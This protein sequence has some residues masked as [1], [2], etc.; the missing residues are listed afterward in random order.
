MLR[1]GV[2]S[3]S[4][5]AFPSRGGL[6][7][8]AV[9]ILDQA[10]AAAAAGDS[11]GVIRL[12]ESAA[13]STPG[14]AEIL[15]L[16]APALFQCGRF[17]DSCRR[18]RE[19][20]EL[21]PTDVKAYTQLGLAS[22][23][24]G[25]VN[26]FEAAMGLALAR[27]PQNEAALG[28][29]ARISFE[30]GRYAEA[31][32]FYGRLLNRGTRDADTFLGLGVCLAKGGEWEIAAETFARVILISPTHAVALENLAMAC[33]KMSWKRSPEP[34]VED[35]LGEAD[36]HRQGDRPA[37]QC[38]CLQAAIAL[39][40]GS[41]GPRMQLVCTLIDQGWTERLLQPLEELARVVP[42]N[43]QVWT[44][45]ATTRLGLGDSAGTNRALEQVFAVAPAFLPARRLEADMALKEKRFEEANVLFGR[46]CDKHP[47]DPELILSRGVS[48]YHCGNFSGAVTDFEAVLVVCPK[49]PA[50]TENLQ[51]AKAQRMRQLEMEAEARFALELAAAEDHQIH[52]R[53]QEAIACLE[54]AAS[55]RPENAEVWDAL[56]SLR[57]SMGNFNGAREALKE[58]VR[59]APGLPDLHVRFA[60]ASH[61]LGRL[62]EA[63]CS[64]DDVL[65]R[66]PDHQAALR[67]KGDLLLEVEPRKAADCYAQRIRT[68]PGGVE[69]LIR[70]GLAQAQG[71]ATESARTLFQSVLAIDPN[72]A[73]A[74]L[75]LARI[76]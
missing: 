44:A 36:F 16:L 34:R 62:D 37:L 30:A 65:C 29:L 21:R 50:A 47:Q 46:L 55:A 69:D 5:A 64:I 43:V 27:D 11:D 19:L 40:P 54:N 42:G 3:N 71:G 45:L 18:F 61:A 39:D 13:S 49:H 74:K 7:P 31:G 72:H 20:I 26:E 2:P 17:V 58:A 15:E 63:N 12:L 53:I 32:T 4:P 38:L 35:L 22:L 28:L 1:D 73:L 14:H 68:T 59:L 10:E 52:G 66:V 48:A 70:L 76:A 75:A 60:M 41:S 23:Q 8:E 67:L 33:A 9:A 24:A 6:P 51:R 57:F 25:R 56:G